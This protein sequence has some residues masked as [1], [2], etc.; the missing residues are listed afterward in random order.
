MV[1]ELTMGFWV[2]LH[3]RRFEKVLWKKTGVI[4]S[5]F[6]FIPAK[7]RNL[8]YIR[9]G[10]E[11]INDLRNRISHHEPIW[12]L[13]LLAEYQLLQEALGWLSPPEIINFAKGF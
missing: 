2:S 4:Q 3:Y 9:P 11:K 12:Q 8:L 13:N 6:P 1:A 7:V 10:L 5:V